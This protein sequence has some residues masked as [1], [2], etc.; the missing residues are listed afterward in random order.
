[1]A[2]VVYHFRRSVEITLRDRSVEFVAQI[3][4]LFLEQFFNV[5]EMWLMGVLE[6]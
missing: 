2:T 4:R 3:D 5:N 6:L 1:L